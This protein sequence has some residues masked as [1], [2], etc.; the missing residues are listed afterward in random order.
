MA[1]ELH[2]HGTPQHLWPPLPNSSDIHSLYYDMWRVVEKEVTK[3]H[4]HGTTASSLVQA[5]ALAEGGLFAFQL[6]FNQW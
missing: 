3:H 1:E 6:G 5:I 4:P 2:T